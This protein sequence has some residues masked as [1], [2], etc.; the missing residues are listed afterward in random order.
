MHHQKTHIFSD[1][2]EFL[3]YLGTKDVKLGKKLL[4]YRIED[5]VHEGFL[6]DTENI[7][8]NFYQLSFSEFFEGNLI[9]DHQ[10][11]DNSQAFIGFVSPLNAY[12]ISTQPGGW[13]GYAIFF[14]L[15]FAD[16]SLENSQ[17]QQDFPFIFDDIPSFNL[18]GETE[19]WKYL[20]K[21]RHLF[22]I[23]NGQHPQKE[24]LFGQGLRDLMFQLKLDYSPQHKELNKVQYQKETTFHFLKLVNQFFRK[25]HQI[26][27]YA[28]KMNLSY[29]QLYYS[30]KNIWGK[31]P[32]E[33]IQ[34][35]LINEARMHMDASQLSI[36]EIAFLLHFQELGHFSR[37]VKNQLGISPR[38]YIRT[39]EEGI[40]L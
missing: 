39:R 37:F 36:S 40:N 12:N 2:S 31:S 15:D 8:T 10:Q 22:E 34:H 17:F 16:F 35:K 14:S 24:L 3:S 25:Q 38:E 18:E 28:D 21:F 27:F 29:D 26:S 23:Y 7:R 20:R 1:P 11:I 9:R 6:F 19:R 4:M 32:A 13:K 30:V 33:I 5:L